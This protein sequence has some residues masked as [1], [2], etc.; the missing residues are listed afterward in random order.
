MMFKQRNAMSMKTGRF[1]FTLI[2][3]LVVIAII[4][5]LASMLLPAMASSRDRARTLTCANNEKQLYTALFSYDSDYKAVPY[6]CTGSPQTRWYRILAVNGYITNDVKD[7]T[8][9]NNISQEYS[10]L[11]ESSVARCPDLVFGRGYGLNNNSRA[12]WCSIMQFVLP[13]QK[14]LVIDNCVYYT[15]SSWYWGFETYMA[16]NA[17]MRL[18]GANAAYADGH[19]RFVRRFLHS[20]LNDSGSWTFNS[21]AAPDSRYR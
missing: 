18:S 2:E 5:I 13:S 11:S 21:R 17:H 14:V 6:G 3:L 9:A 19:V 8:W 15:P 1:I 7:K 20:E 4:A 10:S 16:P 12:S